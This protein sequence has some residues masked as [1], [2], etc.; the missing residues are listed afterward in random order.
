MDDLKF[1][2]WITDL[3]RKF[4]HQSLCLDIE[5]MGINKPI[6]VVGIWQ[7]QEGLVDCQQF[8]CGQDLSRENLADAFKNCKFILA[9][10]GLFFDVPKIRQ[11]FGD[12]ISKDVK[13]FD[14][15]IIAERIWGKKFKLRTLEETYGIKR[16]YSETEKKRIA[17]KLWNK[18]VSGD[19]SALITLLEYNKQDVENVFFI[20]ERLIKDAENKIK[21]LKRNKSKQ[22]PKYMWKKLDKIDINK[23]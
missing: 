12:V 5:T 23:I 13:V 10:N 11:E 1:L 14:T 15:L 4:K 8:I 22:I 6:S 18:Y 17:V 2:E 20:A 19:K 7:P 3:Y 21:E 9:H 16:L